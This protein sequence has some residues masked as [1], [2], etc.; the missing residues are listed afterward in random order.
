M[1]G[2]LLNFNRVMAN[3]ST[4]LV[5]GFIP[6]IVYKY[7]TDSK[8]Q[9][10]VLTIILE[11]LISFIFNVILKNWLIKKPQLFLFLRVIPIIVYQVLLLYVAHNPYL[12]VVGIGIAFSLSYTFK[13]IPN[14]VLFSYINATRKSGTGRQLALTKLLDQFALILGTIVGGIALDYIDAYILV[15]ISIILYIIGALP[16][17]I[18]YITHK[19]DGNL[20]Q[21]YSTYAH[22]SLKETSHNSVVANQV[23]RKMQFLYLIFY[24]LQ[25][26][27]N[28]IYV[29]IP[30]L[31][32][33]LTGRFTDA[34]I[35]TA[36]FDGAYGLGC[37]VAGIIDARK[38]LTWVAMVCG[39][40]VGIIGVS[41]IFIKSEFLWAFYLLCILLGICYAFAFIFMYNRMLT[42][43]KLVGRGT[44]CVINRINMYSLSTCFACVFG[45][46]FP[47]VS[48]F[49]VAGLL[50]IASG[51]ASPFIEEKTRR[52]LVDHLQDNE[53]RKEESPITYRD[54]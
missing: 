45:L 6:A 16:L 20:N 27:V 29:L 14:E 25:E 41:M 9:L 51:V 37:Y 53:V 52:I 4:K 1:E 47:I 13:N 10:A 44:T 38:D 23:S 28:A 5:G 34:A 33:V 31:T 43:T 46:V 35:A 8:M 7:A 12:C 42:K 26:S 3:F 18:Y 40:F 39:I 50:S 24:F 2:K 36:L 48:C 19:K 49:I 21:E 32:F 30:L 11:F 15:I 22:I 54:F 17:L